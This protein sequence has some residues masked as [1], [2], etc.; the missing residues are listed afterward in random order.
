MSEAFD[1]VIVGGGVM[2]ASLAFWLTELGAPARGICV[3]E[4]DR[5]YAQA[6]T[7]LSAA[8]IRLQ[9]SN[10]INVKISQFGVEFIR[11]VAD[12]LGQEGE[13]RDLGFHENGYLFLAGTDEQ[14]RTMREVA[15]IQRAHGAA[16]QTLEPSELAERFP[17][18]D[19]TGV[20]L[21]SFGPRDEGWFDNMGLLWGFRRAAR[22]R[23]VR[24]L[25]GEVS[26][27][28]L[29]EGCVKGI[30]LANG[31]FLHADVAVNAAGTRAA[32]LFRGLGIDIPVEPRKRTV[33]L[34]D[35]PNLQASRA[36]LHIDHLG[37][38]IRPEGRHWIAATVP[39][40][41]PCTA[42]EDFEPNH[43]EFEEILWPRLYERLPSTEIAKVIRAWAGHYDYNVLDQNAI[44]GRWPGYDNLYVMNGFSGHGLQQAPAV[45]R[46]MAEL[47]LTGNYRSLDLSEFGAE[48]ILEGRPF[49]ER[50][51]V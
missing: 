40:V 23:G 33:F 7:A 27:F 43:G 42:L 19:L 31:E 29:S 22:A 41:D 35:V 21:G 20:S 17:W 15:E 38:Y 39:E 9:F 28:L 3:V 49:L 51:I 26:G 45:G 18:L 6:A 14:A 47:I 50:A 37:F 12:W 2:G 8:S 46:G 36:P 48:R 32:N 25:D 16:T 5:S 24:F 11:N 10:P 1:V 30:R 4:R 13:V 34:I 44:L